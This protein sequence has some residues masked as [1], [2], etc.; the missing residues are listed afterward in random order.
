METQ[1][2]QCDVEKTGDSTTG[3]VIT[4]TCHG[5]L[6]VGTTDIL[7]ETVKPLIAEGGKIIV[8]VGDVQYVD[9]MGLGV[10]V[11]LKVS[12]IGAGYCTLQYENLSKKVQELVSMTHLTDLFS[13]S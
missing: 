7:K 4:V 8:D 2:L 12:A 5:R 1:G 9:S 11:G 6:V 13:R 10:L 3:R